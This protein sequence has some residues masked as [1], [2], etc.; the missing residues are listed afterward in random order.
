MALQLSVKHASL[1]CDEDGT[2]LGLASQTGRVDIAHSLLQA[3]ADP[4]LTSQFGESSLYL[5]ARDGHLG[6]VSLLLQAGAVDTEDCDGY[7]DDFALSGAVMSNSI[8]T[9]RL[10]LESDPGHEALNN[11]WV[12]AE[13]PH[14]EMLQLLLE[15]GADKDGRSHLDGS[16]AIM[17]A[18]IE[19]HVEIVR[20][21][22]QACQS[23][24]PY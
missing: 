5:A 8:D 19:G 21:L 6:I 3:G 16:T 18:S 9:V 7:H 17:R 13:Q 10:L 2:A 20:L 4:N 24:R 23:K 15:A 12:F 1:A 22:L 14:P 11:A